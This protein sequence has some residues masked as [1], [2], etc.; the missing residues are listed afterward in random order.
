MRIKGVLY[1][2]HILYAYKTPFHR[3]PFFDSSSNLLSLIHGDNASKLLS[4]KVGDS[5]SK[6][7]SP[8]VGDSNSKLL[9]PTTLR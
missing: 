9:S 8:K 1:A 7:L 3:P 2:Q 4:P 5:N 6:L